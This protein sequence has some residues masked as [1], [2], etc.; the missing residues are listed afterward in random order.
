MND[1]ATQLNAA[2]IDHGLIRL[3]WSDAT[4]SIF[5]LM[6]LRIIVDRLRLARDADP[7]LR[8]S[9]WIPRVP[10]GRNEYH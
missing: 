2:N 7:L 4:S 9:L 5:H 3:N 6:R 1:D 10:G 8:A